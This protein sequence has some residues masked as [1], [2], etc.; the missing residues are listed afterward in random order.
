[1]KEDHLEK[2]NLDYVKEAL[3]RSNINNRLNDDVVRQRLEGELLKIMNRVLSGHNVVNLVFRSD[4]AILDGPKQVHVGRKRVYELLRGSGVTNRPDL[5]VPN[6]L[7]RAIRM[8]A[9]VGG[10]KI[11]GNA[12]GRE[13]HGGHFNLV[14]SG[15]QTIVVAP[16]VHRPT[17]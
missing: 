17:Y 8:K 13:F 5:V 16:E 15:V 1:M 4:G 2:T 12:A 6:I 9:T 14:P 7:E 3:S 10:S 11:M